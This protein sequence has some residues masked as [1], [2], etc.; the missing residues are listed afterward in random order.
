MNRRTQILLP[1]IISVALVIGILLGSY[2]SRKKPA[3]KYFIYAGKGKI[4]EV[5]NYIMGEYVDSV[6]QSMLEEAAVVAMLDSLDPHSVYIPPVDLSAV[7][8]SIEGQFSGIGVQF[9]M[10]NDTVIV[11]KTIPNGPSEKIGILAGDRIIKIND[12]V[13]AG[14]KLN[15]NYI[16][17]RLKGPRDTKVHVSIARSDV[18]DLIEF[19]IIRGDIP[20]TS[21]DVSYLLNKTTAIIKVSSF[22]AKT[23]EEFA[24]ALAK[25]EQQGMKELILDLRSNGGG[26]LNSA[27]DMVNHFLCKDH[28]IVY[29]QGRVT[30]RR[31]ELARVNGRY[32]DLPLIVLIDEF[33]ASASEIV[34]GALQDNDRAIIMGRRSFGKGLVQQQIPLS[35]GSA[36]RLTIARYYTPAGRCIQKPYKNEEE[37]YNELFERYNKGE[38]Y[39]ADSLSHSDT[40]HYKTIKGRTVYGGGGITP[41]IFVAQDTS[42]ITKYF[43]QIANKGLIYKFGFNF[44]DRN[45]KDLAPYKDY[46]SLEKYLNSISITNKFIEY[47][48]ANGVTKNTNDIAKSFNLIDA[49]VKANVA[50]DI[51]DNEGFYPFISRIDNSLQKALQVLKD[52]NRYNSILRIK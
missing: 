33:S 46:I 31:D 22:T 5:L 4:N 17:K 38:L 13:V 37:Y 42:E 30:P 49:Q 20:L 43:S 48:A 23:S 7:N 45:R 12:S 24:H 51:L 41:D 6:S 1:L 34:A 15:S 21:V 27:I 11:I 44:A 50:R 35:D 18:K 8:E 39:N 3:D 32:A 25:L 36:L 14:L 47:A 10:Q 2:I 26:L 19:D 16:V 28:L 9:N 29:T 40:T 52:K